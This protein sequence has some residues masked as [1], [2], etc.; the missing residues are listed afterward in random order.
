MDHP[1]QHPVYSPADIAAVLTE[2]T[3]CGTDPLVLRRWAGRREVHTAM[4]RASKALSSVRLPGRT[5]GGGW[6]E[7]ALVEGAWMRTR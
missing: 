1:T 5:P 2:L 6:V 7:F 4:V 3:A